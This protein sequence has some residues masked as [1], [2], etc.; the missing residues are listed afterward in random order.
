M[1]PRATARIN[2]PIGALVHLDIARAWTI[3]PFSL[4]LCLRYITGVSPGDRVSKP[5]YVFGVLQ[6]GTMS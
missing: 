3:G 2:Q 4:S 5:T 6:S 1:G